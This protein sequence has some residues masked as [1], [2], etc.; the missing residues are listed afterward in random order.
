[1][2]EIH[3]V[4]TCQCNDCMKVRLV[5]ALVVARNMRDITNKDLEVGLLIITTMLSQENL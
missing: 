4:C 3:D 5:Y 2:K 1:M